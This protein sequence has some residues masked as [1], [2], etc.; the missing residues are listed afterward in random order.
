MA[1]HQDRH[2]PIKHELIDDRSIF[3]NHLVVHNTDEGEFF[4]SFFEVVQPVLLGTPDEQREQLESIN[5]VKAKCVSR[6]VISAD[7]VPGFIGAI[8]ERYERYQHDQRS[9]QKPQRRRSRNAG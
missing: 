5:E 6:I 8:A 1:S 9:P 4:L 2:V 3:A 7:R